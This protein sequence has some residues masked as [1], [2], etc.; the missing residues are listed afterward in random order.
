MFH[1]SSGVLA[2]SELVLV[3]TVDT[4]QIANICD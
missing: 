3:S 2:E 4:V 1:S